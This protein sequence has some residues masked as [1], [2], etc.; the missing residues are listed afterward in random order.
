LTVLQDLD[1]LKKN[2]EG[3]RIAIKW[4]ETEFKKGNRFMRTQRENEDLA[5]PLL[6]IPGKLGKLLLLYSSGFSLS[7]PFQST[8]REA[9][10]FMNIAQFANYIIANNTTE[11]EGDDP[12]LTMLTGENLDNR[13]KQPATTS[14]SSMNYVGILQSV[15]IKYD[16]V[17]QFYSKCKKK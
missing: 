11:D 2:K 13:K 4:L 9:T 5:L 8:E 6:K 10:V 16:Q 17:G 3:A 14:N 15:P 12:V 7:S 1:D